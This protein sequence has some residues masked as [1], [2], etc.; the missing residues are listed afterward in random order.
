GAEGISMGTFFDFGEHPGH[1]YVVATL[2]PL[3]SFLVVLLASGLRMALRQYRDSEG[4]AGSLFRM[5]GGDNPKWPAYLPTSASGAACVLCVI[6][7]VRF[8]Q[9]H[10][11]HEAKEASQSRAK[12]DA[13]EHG[14]GWAGRIDWASV[15]P[16][17]LRDKDQATV[18]QLGYRIDS[19]AAL[20]FLM[21][22]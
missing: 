22:T 11:P 6:G 12:K 14:G 18:L 20:M 15:R 1:M 4:P 8:Q 3:A 19:L 10:G 2:L 17:G 9:E 5:L 21:V 13:E 7:F 16:A